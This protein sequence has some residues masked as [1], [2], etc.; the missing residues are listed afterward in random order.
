VAHRQ[1]RHRLHTAGPAPAIA[2]GDKD[3]T[4][5]GLRGNL[6]VRWEYTPGSALFVVW[7][8]SRNDDRKMDGLALGPS[9]S[10]L[11]ELEADNIVLVK[12]SHYFTL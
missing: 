7:T 3:F 11:F 1:R 2:I 10:R 5:K 6:I 8:Q 12:W 9:A 4:Y